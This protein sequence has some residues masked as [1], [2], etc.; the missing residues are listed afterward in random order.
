MPKSILRRWL[1]SS[2]FGRCRRGKHPPNEPVYFSRLENL[3]NEE[4]KAALIESPAKAAS[5]V[6]AAATAG[7]IDAQL[8][9]ANM[10]LD[11][12]GTKRDPAR[13]FRWFGI[14]ALSKRADAINMLGRCHERGWGTPIDFEKAAACYGDAA[15]KSLDW[16]QYNLAS[17]MLDGKIATRDPDKAF[18]LLMKAVK[19]GH[20]KSLNLVGH[21]YEHGSGCSKDMNEAEQWYFRSAEGGDFRGQYRYSELLFSRGLVDE[22]LLWLRA[23]IDNAPARFCA[24]L[25]DQLLTHP[26]PCLRAMEAYAR[27]RA[28]TDDPLAPS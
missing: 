22:A 5:W 21:C 25:A 28:G 7:N 2:P 10:L 18:D 24:E 4:W 23:A 3:T 26:E 6:Y 12:H 17:L 14:A 27:A 13:A 9:W 20:I 19:Q 11:G 1:S 15:E 16:A 8:A